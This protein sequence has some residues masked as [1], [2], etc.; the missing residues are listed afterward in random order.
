MTLARSLLSPVLP[1][2]AFAAWLAWLPAA[3][4]IPNAPGTE[5]GTPL[6]SPGAAQAV[7]PVPPPPSSNYSAEEANDPPGRVGR[8]A[9]ITG[10]VWQFDPDSGCLL[11]TSPSP[12]DS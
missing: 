8:L 7:Q 11:Y 12:R 9:D 5:I 10:Q 4:Q 3:A 2:A 1:A 6:A